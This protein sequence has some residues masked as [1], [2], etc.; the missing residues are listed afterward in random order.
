M[1]EE[2]RDL[3]HSLAAALARV[4][5]ERLRC[6]RLL[7]ENVE[8]RN[9]LRKHGL[10]PG[11]ALPATPAAIDLGNSKQTASTQTE[12]AQASFHAEI[13]YGG[14]SVRFCLLNRLLSEH[15]G[16]CWSMPAKCMSTLFNFYSSQAVHVVIKRVH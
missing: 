11:E 7:L 16:F 2:L 13:M 5:V 4:E 14:C 1:A 3:Q 10:N 8:L 9:V 12:P 15:P 6:K